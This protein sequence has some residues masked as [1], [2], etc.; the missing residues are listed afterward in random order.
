MRFLI[1]APD[2]HAKY[3]VGHQLLRDEIARQHEVVSFSH[4]PKDDPPNDTHIP[5]LVTNLKPFEV[6]LL[7]GP[8]YAGHLTG[9]A[10]VPGLRVSIFVD[11]VPPYIEQYHNFLYKNKLD[12]VFVNCPYSLD[13]FIRMQCR[14]VIPDNVAV[15]W[16]AFSV[17][18]DYFRNM[19]IRRDVDV[20]A[21]FSDIPWCYRLRRPIQ[22]EITKWGIKAI[23]G[24]QYKSNR[25]KHLDYVRLLNRSKIFVTSNNIYKVLSMK[26]TEAMA[27]GAL[28]LA[29]KP[30]GLDEQGYIDGKHLVLYDGMKDLKDKV[31]YYLSHNTEREAIANEGMKLTTERHSNVLRV[32]E[33]TER[34]RKRI[35]K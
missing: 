3:N 1:L 22:R 34:I 21:I 35:V 30:D 14:G 29:D 20:S 26:Y 32:K 11:Y 24:G 17:D 2:Q 31:F 9:V 13:Y 8:K 23:V 33:M 4:W 25:I 5:N 18:T 27:C 12:L 16:Q 28:L 15:E 6:I 19:E 7:E 10:D